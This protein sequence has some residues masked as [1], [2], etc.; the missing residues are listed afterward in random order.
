MVDA[1]LSGLLVAPSGHRSPLLLVPIGR[2][3][4]V[5]YYRQNARSVPVVGEQ[6]HE[7][8]LQGRMG[9]RRSACLTSAHLAFEVV[10]GRLKHTITDVVGQLALSAGLA[11]EFGGPLRES[12]PAVSDR[13]QL[14][15]SDIVLHTHRRDENVVRDAVIAIG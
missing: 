2:V 11:L 9:P 10:E 8:A 12:A 3:E 13:R 14:Q 7:Y 1:K 5:K 15:S 4:L 6:R